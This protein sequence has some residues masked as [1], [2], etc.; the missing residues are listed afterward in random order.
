MVDSQPMRIYIAGQSSVGVCCPSC[1]EWKTLTVVP[2][3]RAFIIHCNC[4]N[5][6]SAFFDKRKYY[7]KEVKLSG[8]YFTDFD[9]H[10]GI[11]ITAVNLSKIGIGFRSAVRKT[12]K[13]G[14]IVKI[15]FSLRAPSDSITCKAKVIHMRNDHVGAEFLNLDAH[16]NKILGFFLLP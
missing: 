15:S 9:Q 16:S 8:L 6:F 5:H 11:L 7:R 14:D 10:H 3:H 13:V 4:G 1:G 2:D 12:L